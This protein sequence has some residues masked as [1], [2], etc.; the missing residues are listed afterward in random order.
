[1]RSSAKLSNE[2]TT[3]YVPSTPGFCTSYV[4]RSTP[5]ALALIFI[6]SLAAQDLRLPLRT[7]V[8]AFRGSGEWQEVTFERRLVPSETALIVCDMWDKH[9]CRG[10]SDRV[11][12]LARKMTPVIDRVRKNGVLVIW[13]PS[14]TMDFY[15]DAPQR[16]TIMAMPRATPPPPLDLTSPPLPIDDS[17]GGCDTTE[18]FYKAWTRQNA[19][20]HIAPNDLISDKGDEV[21]S[22]L[23]L[24]G[25]RTVLI[26]GVHA[27]M[28]ILNRPFAIKQLTKWGFRCIL[29]RDLTDAMYNPQD[30]PYVSHQRGTELVIEYIEKYWAPTVLSS[31]LARSK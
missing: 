7:R 19:S 1:M 5:A 28:C 31:D 30:R 20:L 29:V 22:A 17:K 26:A 11:E 6:A 27:N 9:W 15:K 18:T 12:Q 8:E 21:Y 13:S 16:L 3:C 4:V 10:A 25:I 2:G 24:R 14:E 23:K